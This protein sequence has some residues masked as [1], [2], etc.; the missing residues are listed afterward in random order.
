MSSIGK[1]RVLA[2]IAML[3][4]VGLATYGLLNYT[5]SGPGFVSPD[6]SYSPYGGGPQVET[7]HS[8]GSHYGGSARLEVAFGTVCVVLAIILWVGVAPR[9]ESLAPLSSGARGDEDAKRPSD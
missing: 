7:K 8:Y 5:P 9:Y 6:D 4:G 2:A 1:I 3:V